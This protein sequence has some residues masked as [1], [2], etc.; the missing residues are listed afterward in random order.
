MPPHMGDQDLWADDRALRDWVAGCGGGDHTSHMAKAGKAAGFDETF[1]KAH[2]ANRCLPELR[3][4]DRY[5]M[6]I[7]AVE[8]HPAYHELLRL[9]I[10]HQAHNFAWHNEGRAGHLGQ[11]ALTYMF[12]QPEGGVMCPMAMTY[13]VVPSLR[14]TPEIEAEWMP[15]VLSDVYDPR[16]IP[17]TEKTGALIGMFMT[18]KQGGSDVRSNST[19]AVPMSL[20]SGTG[21]DYLLTGHKFF[22]SAPMCDAFLVLAN[23][24]SMGIS[25]FLVPRW[26]PDGDRNNLSIQRIKDKLGNRSNASTEI[27]FQDT[28]GVM[29]GEEGRGVRTIIDMVTGNRIYCA[30]SSAGIMRQALV[31]AL[32]HTAHRSAFKKRLIEQPLMQNVLADMAIE[33][34]AALAL[35]LRVASAMDHSDEPDE[36]A[37][38]RIGTAIAKYWNTKR[39]PYLVVEALECHGGPGYI[40]ESI[41]PRLYREAPLNSI[42]EGSGNVIGL[43]VLRVISREPEVVWVFMAEVEKARG[44]DANLDRIIDDLHG[45]LKNPDGMEIRMRMITEMM[46]LAL[47][48][49]LLTQH[50]PVAVAKAFCASRLAPRYRG[51]FGTLPPGCDLDAIIARATPD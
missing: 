34:E 14:T 12:S 49:A 16:D 11:S 40:E 21:A 43:D 32:H 6:R 30:M 24:D 25:C 47:Q 45:E 44:S 18:E 41:M 42:W 48:G 22:C 51:A 8:F 5:G 20:E 10:S 1:E 15:R 27:E 38:A 46:A 31:Q 29:V 35:G 28:Y 4:F 19:V 3:A 39:C 33:V 50:A 7:N 13:S 37:L 26:R 17:V 36:A 9:V 2:Q 23:T